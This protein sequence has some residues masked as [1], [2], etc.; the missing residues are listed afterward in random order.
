MPW[1]IFV[2]VQVVS[3][4]PLSAAFLSLSHQREQG[5]EGLLGTPTPPSVN[6][7]DPWPSFAFS[8]MLGETSLP[9]GPCEILP[10]PGTAPSLLLWEW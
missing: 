5:G 4:Q 10:G 8:G 7:W 6:A 3:V 1:V 2:N 9:G